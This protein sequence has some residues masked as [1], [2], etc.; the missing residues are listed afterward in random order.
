MA[1][2]PLT[3]PAMVKPEPA[4]GETKSRLSNVK[5]NRNRTTSENPKTVRMTPAEKVM[6]S[7]LVDEIQDLTTKTITD[8][9]VLRAALYLAKEVGPEKM[10]EMIKEHL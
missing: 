8:S 4:P 3:R 2:G 7:E 10:L 1:K 5:V 6:C 9:T